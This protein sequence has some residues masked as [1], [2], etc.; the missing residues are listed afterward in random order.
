[1]KCTICNIEKPFAEY[2][3]LMSVNSQLVKSKSNR[4][5]VR[6][7][8]MFSLGDLLIK[9]VIINLTSFERYCYQ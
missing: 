4:I 3:K 8:L 9:I 2:I 1:M 6:K 7:E 5:P